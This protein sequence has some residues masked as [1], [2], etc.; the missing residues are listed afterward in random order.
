MEERVPPLGGIRHSEL[1]TTSLQHVVL[2]YLVKLLLS[3]FLFLVMLQI[4]VNKDE[5]KM[6]TRNVGQCPT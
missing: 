2:L 3:V 5:Y 6:N 1:L 4:M